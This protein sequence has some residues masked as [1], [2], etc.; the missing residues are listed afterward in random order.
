MRQRHRRWRWAAASRAAARSRSPRSR[1]SAGSSWPESPRRPAP[2]CRSAPGRTRAGP[3]RRCRPDRL[4][5]STALVT[6]RRIASWSMSCSWKARPVSVRMPQVSTTSGMLSMNASATP[7]RPCVTPAPGTTFTTRRPTSEVRDTASA[8]N[9]APCSSVTST[10]ATA[11]S[12]ER[13][14]QLDVVRARDAE[15]EARAGVLE[16]PDDDSVAQLH[17]WR[18]IE[19]SARS[20][21]AVA[22]APRRPDRPAP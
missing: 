10:G 5:R 11:D 19:R 13:V 17:T 3:S 15:R 12:L 8:M 4:G 1:A 21:T 22:H 9:E 14:V 18:F 20:G 2:A 6:G 16:R 7:E